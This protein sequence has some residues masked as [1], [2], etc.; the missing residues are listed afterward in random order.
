MAMKRQSG[1]LKEPRLFPLRS[2]DFRKAFMENPLIYTRYLGNTWVKSGECRHVKTDIEG[3]YPHTEELFRCVFASGSTS[4][5]FADM[6]R[7]DKSSNLE[8]IS[9]LFIKMSE[10]LRGLGKQK[11]SAVVKVLQNKCIYPIRRN[12]EQSGFD[13]LCKVGESKNWFIPDSDHLLD[14]FSGKVP[15]LAFKITDVQQMEDLLNAFNL[16]SR[17]LSRIVKSET[18]AKGRIIQHREYSQLFLIKTTFI[19]R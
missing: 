5:A 1:K 14:R 15:L 16:D 10:A 2:P 13:D 19:A 8:E 12:T 18:A 9:Q 7:I 4:D 11:V 17:K 6:Q 3:E